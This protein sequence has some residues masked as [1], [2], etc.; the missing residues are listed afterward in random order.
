MITLTLSRGLDTPT[1]KR[2]SVNKVA[3]ALAQTNSLDT[4]QGG[5]IYP[6]GR[7]DERRS[8][9][10]GDMPRWRDGVRSAGL[11]ICISRAGE[12][13]EDK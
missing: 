7:G 13:Q 9:I 1:A 5:R 2:G 4:A 12:P 8:Q 6:V 11:Q 10:K 3:A